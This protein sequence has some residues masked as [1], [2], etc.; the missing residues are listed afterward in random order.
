MQKPE[1]RKFFHIFIVISLLFSTAGLA[2][3]KHFCGE[4]LAHVSLDE[5]PESC[6]DQ[7]EIPSGCEC[8]N[9]VDLLALEDEFHLEHQQ[10][11]ITPVVQAILLDFSRLLAFSPIKEEQSNK[12]I[13]L[14]YPPFAESD[15]HIRVQ[16]FLL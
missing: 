12:L 11:K 2:V 15:I 1:V 5:E 6:C 13:T 4:V 14:K 16:S 8:H 7:P 9:E 10:V 3:T